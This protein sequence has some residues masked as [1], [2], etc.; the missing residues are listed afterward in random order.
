M[1][2]LYEANSVN[3]ASWP[4]IGAANTNLC[5]CHC[6][7]NVQVFMIYDKS[8]ADMHIWKMGGLHLADWAEKLAD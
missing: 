5:D 7:T 4:I 3:T 1:S 2:K 8:L 6:F